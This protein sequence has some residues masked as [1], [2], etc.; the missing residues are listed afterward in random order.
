MYWTLLSSQIN[1]VFFVRTAAAKN[2]PVAEVTNH[3][4][5]TQRPVKVHQELILV[6][7]R[8]NEI[9]WVLAPT[10]VGNSSVED[11]HKYLNKPGEVN[12]SNNNRINIEGG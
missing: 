3:H 7:Y 2:L 4:V 6:N 8:R 10:K 5:K 12:S 1:L 9:P 11:F